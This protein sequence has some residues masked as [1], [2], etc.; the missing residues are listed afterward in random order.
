VRAC[1]ADR[2]ARAATR[3][4]RTTPGALTVALAKKKPDARRHR[5]PRRA[6]TYPS[7]E[8]S[9]RAVVP[10]PDGVFARDMRS[11]ERLA[12]CVRSFEPSLTQ[13]SSA[14]WCVFVHHCDAGDGCEKQRSE[15]RRETLR[16]AHFSS[17]RLHPAP[18]LRRAARGRA[19]C[20]EDGVPAGDLQGRGD[21]QVPHR[22][23]VEVVRLPPFPRSAR[24]VFD[25]SS[26]GFS[27]L[28]CASPADPPRVRCA[29][30]A[31]PPRVR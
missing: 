4:W 11:G 16:R 9:Y 3:M 21:P 15:K 31:D 2:R 18:L 26:C 20:R 23:H 25:R 29:S 19:R 17:S 12:S 24:P 6:P 7:L 8:S 14:H 22:A 1:R 27:R 13:A 30:P 10:S 5:C 28:P